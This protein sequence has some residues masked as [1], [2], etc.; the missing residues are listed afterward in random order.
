M[1][2]NYRI[3]HLWIVDQFATEDF[4][5]LIVHERVAGLDGVRLAI[6]AFEF[7][8]HAGPEIGIV[9]AHD[10][11]PA[12]RAWRPDTSS[13]AIGFL[14]FEVGELERER[15]RGLPIGLKGS[16]AGLFSVIPSEYEWSTR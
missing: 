3:R 10:G 9:K 16:S 2:G 1:S 4:P 5:L 8:H 14:A 12:P 13:S 6:A 7:Q 11:H 15:V